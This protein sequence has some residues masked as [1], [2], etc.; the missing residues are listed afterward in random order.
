M[1]SFNILRFF[2]GPSFSETKQSD[3]D[4]HLKSKK[5]SSS[6][7]D[8]DKIRIESDR[9]KIKIESDRDKIRIT[10]NKIAYERDVVIILLIKIRT[11]D[12]SLFNRISFKN[13]AVAKALYAC[14][15]NIKKI[16]YKTQVEQTIRS[17][18]DHIKVFFNK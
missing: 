4:H 6:L 7:S 8:R 18:L 9:D 15:S 13:I 11:N 17:F 1:S 3:S 2:S 14:L 10:Y 16:Q 5:F 12:I